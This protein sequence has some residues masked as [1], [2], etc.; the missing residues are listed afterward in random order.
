MVLIVLL[1]S[2]CD[3]TG[4]QTPVTED[5]C[6]P[7]GSYSEIKPEN[8]EKSVAI[9][10]SWRY[11]GITEKMKLYEP[12]AQKASNLW[13][14]GVADSLENIPVE[15]LRKDSIF[16]MYPGSNRKFVLVMENT[17]SEDIYFF[18]SP[19]LVDPTDHALGFKFHCLCVNHTFHIPPGK[20]WYRV[21]KLHVDEGFSGNRLEIVHDLVRVSSRRASPF[22]YPQSGEEEAMNDFRNPGISISYS[23]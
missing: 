17:G 23:L 15:T 22:T 10:V 5:R 7:T 14:T 13:E 9:V 11:K 4:L 16:H 3:K 12:S 19:H 20:I 8:F 18:A 2:G 6:R 21:V 1:F